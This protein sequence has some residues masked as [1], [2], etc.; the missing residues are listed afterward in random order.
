MLTLYQA[1][2]F[3]R[4]GSIDILYCVQSYS[5]THVIPIDYMGF[6]WAKDS[7]WLERFRGYKKR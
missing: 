6:S 3:E 5:F 7:N 2:F 4:H 1:I